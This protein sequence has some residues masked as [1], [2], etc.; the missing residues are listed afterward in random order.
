MKKKYIK[1]NNYLILV[2]FKQRLRQHMAIS[3]SS[4]CPF[5]SKHLCS[6]I[7]FLLPGSYMYMMRYIFVNVATTNSKLSTVLVHL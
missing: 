3:A 2:N 5:Y 4:Y 7:V 1:N 6:V